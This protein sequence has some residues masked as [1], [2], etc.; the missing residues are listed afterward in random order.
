MF[1]GFSV[2]VLLLWGWPKGYYIRDY[3]IVILGIPLLDTVFAILRRYLKAHL[4]ADQ[5]PP[6]PA[7]PD[8]N[9]PPPAVLGI[10]GSAFVLGLMLCLTLMTTKQAAIFLVILSTIVLVA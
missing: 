1:L 5:A 7:N 3:T 10:Y 8:G 2:A 4:P 9:E 6:S